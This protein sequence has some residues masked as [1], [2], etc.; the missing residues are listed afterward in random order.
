MGKLH[1][2]RRAILRDPTKWGGPWHYGARQDANGNWYSS[3]SN[4]PRWHNPHYAFIQS[5]LTT[6]RGGSS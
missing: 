4:L 2:L 3:G 5:V 1:T 6:L